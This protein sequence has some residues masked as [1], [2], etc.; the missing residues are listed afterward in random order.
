DEDTSEEYVFTMLDDYAFLL[1]HTYFTIRSASQRVTDALEV[2][3]DLYIDE[4]L[5][6]SDEV[7]STLASD[8]FINSHATDF[9]S[10]SASKEIY[11]NV[12]SFTH[13]N[14]AS[15][16]SYSED[17]DLALLT[18][19]YVTANWTIDGGNLRYEKRH[20]FTSAD[21]TTY[22]AKYLN[23]PYNLGRVVTTST[24]STFY[25]NTSDNHFYLKFIVPNDGYT[26]SDIYNE[27]TL[28]EVNS[29]SMDKYAE[30]G[31]NAVDTSKYENYYTRVLFPEFSASY[32]EDITPALE[33][34]GVSRAFKENN[35]DLSITKEDA[36]LEAIHQTNSFTI[37]KKGLDG[38]GSVSYELKWIDDS[39]TGYTDIYYDFIIDRAFIYILTDENNIPIYIGYVNN[40]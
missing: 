16:Y 17:T 8:Y 36:T 21:G 24:Y 15:K 14:N 11:R 1:D 27:D 25:T 33:K 7:L 32:D 4:S 6:Y 9:T 30:N 20:E 38:F 5:S 26:L 2:S 22:K 12:R 37:D 29:L 19:L 3:S 10:E 35:S 13:K 23:A 28:R 31:Y 40:I 18:S 34:A 39:Y